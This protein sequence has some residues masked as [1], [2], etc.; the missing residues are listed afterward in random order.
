MRFNNTNVAIAYIHTANTIGLIHQVNQT[1]L[2]LHRQLSTRKPSQPTKA[3][4]P[5]TY[6]LLLS[7]YTVAVYYYYFARKLV[8]ILITVSGRAEDIALDLLAGV[9]LCMMAQNETSSFGLA[10]HCSEMISWQST[11]L[12]R[13]S[14]MRD[15]VIFFLPIVQ[16]RSI[17][18]KHNTRTHTI[19]YDTIRY[20]TIIRD[21]ILTC[22]QKLT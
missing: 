11:C 12:L 19:R 13:S 22:A 3:V 14:P 6:R 17:C 10:H 4:S 18:D 15:I 20:D 16:I 7:T 8:L 21:A 9:K 1:Q 2:G 5:L